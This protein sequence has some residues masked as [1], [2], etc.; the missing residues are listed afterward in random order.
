MKN[1][2][3]KLTCSMLRLYSYSLW[4]KVRYMGD[5]L[6]SKWIGNFVADCPQSVRICKG[7]AIFGGEHVHLGEHTVIQRYSVIEAIEQFSGE[8]FSPEISIGK[9]ANLGEYNHISCIGRLLIGKGFLS[10]RRVT[11]I[12]HNHGSSNDDLTSTPP[13]ASKAMQQGWNY[14]RR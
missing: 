10:G 4:T 9:G 7:V 2:L 11:I 8:Y 5:S 6:Y 1:L 3:R 13:H 12:D 14:H